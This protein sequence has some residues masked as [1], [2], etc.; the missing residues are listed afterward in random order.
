MKKKVVWLVV[1]CLMVLSLVLASCGQAVTEK[2]EAAPAPGEEEVAPPVEEEVVTEEKEMVRDS[3]G[4]LVEKPKY[5]GVITI[6]WGQDVLGFDEVY[7]QGWAA[8]TLN[9]TND[10]LVTGD[11]T[12][13]P[14]GTDEISWNI[15]GVSLPHMQIG[16]LAESWEFP[17]H[18]TIIYHIRKGVRFSLNPDNE[19]SRLVG[20]R[21]V[22]ADDVVYSLMRFST[23][24]GTIGYRDNPDERLGITAP[25]KWTVVLKRAAAD[26]YPHRAMSYIFPGAYGKTIAHE[27]IE[28]WETMRD[29]RQSH[30]TGPYMLVDYVSGSSLTFVKNPNYWMKSPLY[31]EDTL[32]YLD[33]IKVLIIPDASTR[34]SALRTGKVDMGGGYREEYESLTKTNPELQYVKRMT[35]ISWNLYFRMDNPELP[36]YD[37]NVRRAM[38]MAIDNQAIAEHL[39]VGDAEVLTHPVAP[40][41]EFKNIYRPLEEF[42]ESIR[43][44]YEY[45]PD[46]ARQLLAEA[47]YPDGF[48]VQIIA[49]ASGP[50]VASP[51]DLLSVIKDYWKDVGVDLEI[52]LKEYAVWNSIQIG[53]AFNEMLFAYML[54]GNMSS[55]TALTYF[56][57]ASWLNRCYLEDAR[58]DEAYD[59]IR[60]YE[61]DWPKQEQIWRDLI[62]HILENI[63]SI[64]MPTAYVYTFWNPWVKDF[65]GEGTVGFYNAYN[66]L[67][68]IWMDQDA[69]E[70]MTGRR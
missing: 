51:G 4:R 37:I 34:L 55:A 13:G 70:A 49:P 9:L 27:V 64:Q 45:H 52:E 28:K 23:T 22:T 24:K 56:Q 29:W 31:P 69:K 60:V 48:K 65:H 67:N 3:L 54:N 59:Q 26:E 42:S 68:Y 36:W 61:L 20:G 15:L 8:I 63:W 66:Y 16:Q 38:A 58:V 47:G 35:D 12:K 32:P 17:D 57:S 2:E 10:E 39:Y 19:A 5:G 11:W 14:V 53:R 40:F 50:A 33:A 44:L 43:E 1:S 62:P 6:P 7:T 21:E 46:R 41:P 30:G 25:D 18:D